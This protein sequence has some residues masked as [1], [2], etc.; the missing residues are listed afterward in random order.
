MTA[1]LPGLTAAITLGARHD[2][3]APAPGAAGPPTY[4]TAR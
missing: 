3:K 4:E 2:G 1:P